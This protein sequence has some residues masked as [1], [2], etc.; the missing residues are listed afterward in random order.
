MSSL[1]EEQKLAIEYI[2]AGKNTFITGSPGTGKSFTLKHCI[3]YIK[4]THKKYAI[5]S[6]TGCSAVLI[7]GQ[8]LHSY[9]GIGTFNM[10]VEK[11]VSSLKTKYYQKYKN[12]QELQILIIDEISMIDNT[13]FDKISKFLQIIKNNQKHFGGI[14]LIL[15][16]DFCQLSPVCG[17]YC[18]TS[19]TWNNLDLQCVYLTK[20]IRQEN[21]IEFQKIL[22]E[23]RFGKCSKK[24]YEKLL[25]LQDTIIPNATKL[26]SL[27]VDVNM[28]NLFEMKRK[29]KLNTKQSFDDAK[30]IQCFP[31]NIN[32]I[33]LTMLNDNTTYDNDKDIF[34]YNPYSNDKSFKPNEYKIELIKG[35]QVMVTRNINFETGL[36]NG[37]IGTI[38][39]LTTSSVCIIDANQNKHLINY[40]KDVNDNNGMYVKF[41]PI[42]IAYAISIHK[43][44]GATLDNVEVDASS[45]IFA[46]GQL[47]TAISRCRSL[48]N[49]R[50]VNFDRT[51]FI[52]NKL[53]KEF[54]EELSKTIHSK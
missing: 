38:H 2:K 50:L 6:S 23:V 15:V 24:T 27:N 9:L 46:P 3:S 28:I 32:D 11:H 8:T 43:S 10:T 22:E 34:C 52:C 51:S 31:Y 12:I 42:K 30:I 54:Y 41:M 35:I 20:C 47:Y 7:N 16:G 53:V 29:Y 21:D 5:T 14:Q 45:N 39:S 49:I 25:A 19:D 33:E 26:Y 18:F 1:N 37:T 48:T 36:I 13:T 4:S 17:N 40:H 44:Q